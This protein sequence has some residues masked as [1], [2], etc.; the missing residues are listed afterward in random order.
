MGDTGRPPRKPQSEKEKTAE[1][2]RKARKRAYLTAEVA[3][4]VAGTSGKQ[5]AR[6]ESGETNPPHTT[7]QELGSL[8]DCAPTDIDENVD[9]PARKPVIPGF[10]L[11]VHPALDI[12]HQFPALLKTA[13]DL[14]I[15][16]NKEFQKA[17]KGNL[18][19]KPKKQKQRKSETPFPVR[20]QQ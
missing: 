14:V 13:R 15:K 19:F 9:K 6:W 1:G 4:V 3:G 5:I 20:S 18:P 2:L 17:C 11:I 7:V 8:Y 16:L 10:Y 12:E